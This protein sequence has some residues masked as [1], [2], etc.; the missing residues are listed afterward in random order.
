MG[1]EKLHTRLE[2]L[3]DRVELLQKRF[4]CIQNIA[5]ALGSSLQ[6]DEVLH[7]VAEQVTT[8]LDSSRATVFLV[9]E[10][11]RN[12]VAKV[13][14]GPELKDLVLRPGQGIA[15]WVA[16]TGKTLNV[17][18]AYKDK[19]FDP[20]FDR[21][22]G[23]RTR[24]ILCQPMVTYGGKIV[25]VIQVLNKKKGYFTMGDQ[26][27][28]STI[29]TQASITI[30]NSKFFTQLHDANLNL[31]E[32]Q[33]NLKRNYGR[34]ETLYRIQAEMTQTWE[35]QTL[36]EGVLTELLAT[37]RCAAGVVL[38][39]EPAPSRLYV[40]ESKRE[41]VY[42]VAPALL[43]GPLMVVID[44]GEQIHLSTEAL[45]EPTLLHPQLRL[46]LSS[47]LAQPLVNSAGEVF[48]VLAL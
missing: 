37:V 48:G 42:S 14:I 26:D 7:T 17:K 13:I 29:T 2:Y 21:M 27:L 32:A 3:H 23:F 40:K 41:D 24:T 33:E 4:K 11:T 36:F 45:P 25:G 8:M 10:E 28:L 12:L 44:E 18:D 31:R 9:D 30:E 19:R 20:T 6:M 1:E 46:E 47:L 15:G 39:T 16:Q 5:A 38:L 34:L 35:R 22:S 43:E